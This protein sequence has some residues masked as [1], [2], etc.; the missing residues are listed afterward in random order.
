[1]KKFDLMFCYLGNGCTVCNRAQKEH[2]DYKNI[3]HISNAG[4]ISFYIQCETIPG[5]DLIRIEHIAATHEANFIKW[6]DSEI[7]SR[8]AYIYGKML[9]RLPLSIQIEA[10]GKKGTLQ[11]KI[12]AIKPL[13]IKYS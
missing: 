9:D 8:P 11:E 13:Y 3:A 2:G 4:N 1:M 6:L 12:E 5:G 10:M 7:A